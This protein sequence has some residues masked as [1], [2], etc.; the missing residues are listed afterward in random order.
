MKPKSRVIFPLISSES[1]WSSPIE[2]LL[3]VGSPAGFNV[4]TA[5]MYPSVLFPLSIFESFSTSSSE[6]VLF[7]YL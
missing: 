2:E 4:I 3:S 7:D 5:E 6:F 1:S